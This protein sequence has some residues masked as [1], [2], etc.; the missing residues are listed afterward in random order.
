MHM[1][2]YEYKHTHT[3]TQRTPHIIKVRFHIP[4]QPLID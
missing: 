1:Y 3:Y 2:V 4:R